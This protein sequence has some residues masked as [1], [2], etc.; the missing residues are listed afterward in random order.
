LPANEPIGAS[1]FALNA[2]K[3]ARAPGG[4]RSHSFANRYK[5]WK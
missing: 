5:D 2:G 3:D 4:K 1:T